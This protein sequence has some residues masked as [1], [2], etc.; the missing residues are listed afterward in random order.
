M[1]VLLVGLGE[2]GALWYKELTSRTDIHLAGVADLNIETCQKIKKKADC[3]F[4]SDAEKAMNE[5]KPDFIINSSPPDAH[6]A[7]NDLAFDFNIPVLSEKPIAG[8]WEDILHIVSRAQNGQKLMI[9]ENYRYAPT[10]RLIKKILLQKKI[11]NLSGI[12]I[13]F[14]RRHFMENYHKEMLHP[15]LHDVGIHHLDMLRYFTG[16]EAESVYTD[17]FTPAESWYKG[18]SNLLLHITMKNG[19][20]VVYNGS[21][22]GPLNETNWHG[23]W[24]FTGDKGV[25]RYQNSNLYFDFEDP[26]TTQKGEISAVKTEIVAI[27]E[28]ND[29][30]AF[31]I[32]LDAFIAY[33]QHGTLP[34][35]HISDNIKTHNIAHMALCSFETGGKYNAD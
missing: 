12:R 1:R 13:D 35:T 20:K 29:K 16:S 25:L 2:W 28:N 4:Y 11:G 5:L 19:V 32:I 24:I 30:N 23:H 10:C 26:Q 15:M 6:K 9:A 7:I 21:L 3:Q 33:V 31:N 18:Y 22:D 14:H 27:P 17:F 8:N 34:E